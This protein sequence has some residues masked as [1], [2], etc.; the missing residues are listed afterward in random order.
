[1]KLHEQLS[2]KAATGSVSVTV[3]KRTYILTDWPRIL[4]VAHC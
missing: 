4:D 1:M 2:R 3:Q